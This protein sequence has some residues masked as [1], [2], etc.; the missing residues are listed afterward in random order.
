MSTNHPIPIPIPSP[1]SVITCPAPP[2]PCPCPAPPHPTPVLRTTT[3]LCCR[4]GERRF[5]LF[6]SFPSLYVLLLT[7]HIYSFP[8]CFVV[9]L[10]FRDD[11]MSIK[12]VL[13][14]DVCVRVRRRETPAHTT[15][16]RKKLS[17]LPLSHAIAPRFSFFVCVN[18]EIV[19]VYP[20]SHPH[21]FYRFLI[22]HFSSFVV[23]L[24][25]DFCF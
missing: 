17:L 11:A 25:F 8:F 9:I 21:D 16:K 6:F 18:M 19:F 20:F 15:T 14:F 3:V 10:F 2:V 4:G 22:L 12:Y 5:S 1:L 23:L 24:I 7:P 13:F